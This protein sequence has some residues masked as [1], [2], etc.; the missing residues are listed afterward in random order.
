[1][2]GNVLQFQPG[3]YFQANDLT[4][5][6]KYRG[7]G[8]RIEEDV[9]VTKDGCRVMTAALPTDPDEIESWMRDLFAKPAP[10]LG[11]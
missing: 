4:V 5:P 11:L 6:E 9:V 1:M 10:N 7:I 2:V 8:I 3:L